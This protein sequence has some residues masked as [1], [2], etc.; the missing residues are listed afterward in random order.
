M[1]T[2]GLLALHALVDSGYPAVQN[3]ACAHCLWVPVAQVVPA[4]TATPATAVLG[5]GGTIRLT[6]G[7]LTGLTA[8]TT[9]WYRVTRGDGI[10]ATSCADLAV[11]SP[12][13]ALASTTVTVSYGTASANTYTGYIDVFASSDCSS[14]NLVARGTYSVTVRV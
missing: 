3:V 8:T 5:A 6:T 1:Q 2:C 9:Y 13:G 7:A 11:S 12:T 4:I 14:A 10:D